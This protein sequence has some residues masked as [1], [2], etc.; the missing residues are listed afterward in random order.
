LELIGRIEH[1]RLRHSQRDGS[2][3]PWE[4]SPIKTTLERGITQR[5]TDEVFWRS[6]GTSIPV[7]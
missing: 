3:N 4:T 7:E 2:P 1:Q 5:I 6:D